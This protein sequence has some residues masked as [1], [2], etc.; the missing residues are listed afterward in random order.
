[1]MMDMGFLYFPKNKAEYIPAVITL[2]VFFIGAFLTFN[3][4]RKASRR[5]EKRLEM[6]EMNQ[7]NQNHNHS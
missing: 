5:E 6:V 4:I 1:M 2:I 7:N 3:A